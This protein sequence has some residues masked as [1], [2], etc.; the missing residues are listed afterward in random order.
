MSTIKPDTLSRLRAANP[1]RTHPDLARSDTAQAT[2]QR[3]VNDDPSALNP[4][5]RSSPPRVRG[6]GLGVILAVV[7]L[8]GGAAIAA[9]NPFGWWSANPDTARFAVDPGLH[10]RTPRAMH[11]AC[12]SASGTRV[13]CRPTGSGQ[14]YLELDTV[15]LM[16]PADVFTRAHFRRA[17]A[18]AEARHGPS[19]AHLAILRRDLAAVPDSF[20]AELRL[21]N[22]YQTISGGVSRNG[23]VPPRGVPLWLVCQDAGAA[24]SCRDLNGDEH[25]PIGAAIYYAEPAPDWRPAPPQKRDLGLPP[26]ITFTPVEYRFLFDL[27]RFGTIG[28]SSAASAGPASAR[29]RAIRRKVSAKRS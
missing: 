7:L 3:I 20:F 22:D 17:L 24:L 18:R 11:I 14:R 8:G 19:S 26:G 9:T 6:R 21:A 5:R 10:V 28:A 27:A 4:R 1:V 29:P 16:N 12:P 13:L 15:R 2:L 23:R 25:A